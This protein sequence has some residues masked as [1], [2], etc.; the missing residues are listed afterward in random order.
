MTGYVYVWEFV[1]KRERVRDFELAYADDG[2]WVRLFRQ[3]AGYIRTE[4]VRD[5]A[6]PSRFLT[7]D[8][9][10][11]EAAF[12]AFRSRFAKEF[13]ALDAKFASW[14]ETEKEIG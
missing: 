4:L 12:A 6:T 1:V 3:G 2:E 8:Y 10:E 13:E 14:T 7:I 9:W 11:S 5:R